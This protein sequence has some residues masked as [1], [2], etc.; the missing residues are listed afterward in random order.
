M[1][2]NPV[3]RPPAWLQREHEY[4]ELLIAAGEILDR[5]LDYRETLQNVC[6]AA[7][8]TVADL[9]LVDL[10]SGGDLHLAA[11]AHRDDGLTERLRE[12]GKF[13]HHNDRWVPHPVWQAI[14]SREPLLVTDVDEDYLCEHSTSDDHEAFMRDLRYASMI[15]VPLISRTQGVIGAL[16]LVRTRPGSASYDKTDLHF[17][18]DLARHCSSAIAKSMLHAQTLSI[19]TNFQNGALPHVLPAVPG[20]KI[21]A[22]YEP[23]S[24]ELLVGGDWYDAFS[25]PDGRVAVTIGDVLGHGVNAAVWMG[26]LRNQ[27]RATLYTDPDPARALLVVDRL[28]RLEPGG[29]HEDFATALIAI[30][31]PVYQTMSCASAGHPGPL[32]WDVD[33]SVTD[34]FDERMLPLGLRDL[35]DDPRTS[36]SVTL[37]PGTFAVFFTDGL[38]E[39]SRDLS[40]AW[41]LLL[42]TVG[43]PGVRDANFPARAI[44]YAII[45]G[46]KHQDDL[47]ILTLQVNER[48]RIEARP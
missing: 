32:V 22:F 9:C 18:Q 36:L 14:A 15:I 45:P 42:K 10:G 35:G 31:D 5:S 46:D 44:R 26:R 28:M 20:I 47:A 25:L 48:L 19:A 1:P 6:R 24:E 40:A 33:G 3:Q 27:L 4:L 2:V 17:A 8:S 23:S 13:L 30:V 29:S 12:A 39:W 34:P 7:V 21:D 37:H 41:D 43:D 16:T 38:L 11:Y